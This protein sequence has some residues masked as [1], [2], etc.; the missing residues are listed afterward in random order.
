MASP[1]A[2]LI[3]ITLLGLG[4]LLVTGVLYTLATG[5]KNEIDKHELIH[6]A[7]QRHSEYL[8]SL[9]ARTEAARVH[10]NVDVLGPTTPAPAS[11]APAEPVP[12]AAEAPEPLEV[13]RARV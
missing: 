10:H 5:M 7:R 13:G 3:L 8:A 2:T 9:K 11:A 1:F 6:E 12:T 4:Y